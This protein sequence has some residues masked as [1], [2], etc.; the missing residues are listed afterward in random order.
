MPLQVVEIR[1]MQV[2][3]VAGKPPLLLHTSAAC[4]RFSV[5]AAWVLSALLLLLLLLWS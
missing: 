4:R 3:V 2:Q 1:V 5:G